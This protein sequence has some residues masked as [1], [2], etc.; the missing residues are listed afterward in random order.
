MLTLIQFPEMYEELSEEVQQ[1]VGQL[2]HLLEIK[3][4]K[5]HLHSYQVANYAVS[6]AAKM[7][8]P[9]EEIERIRIA[10][11]LHDIGH[12]TVPNMILS[13]AP[14]LTQRELA[15]YKNHC[16]AGSFML[17]NLPSCQEISLY[18]RHHHEQFDGKGYPKRLKG[19]NIPLGARIIAVANHYDRYINP[20]TQHWTK[21]PEDA[22]KELNDKAGTAFDTEIVRAFIEALG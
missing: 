6:I 10:A 8:L 13:K 7:R 19:V 15:A 11:M 9:K 1:I 22:V 20:C 12:L 18:I 16:N 14:Y 3:N 4:P 21:T 2:L 17:E 5:L